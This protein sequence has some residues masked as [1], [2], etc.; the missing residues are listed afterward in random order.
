M[1]GNLRP[2][3][4]PV[5]YGMEVEACFEQ[6]SDAYTLVQWEP[7]PTGRAPVS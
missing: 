5:T 6:I 7:A 1:Y 4:S 3:R 2:D